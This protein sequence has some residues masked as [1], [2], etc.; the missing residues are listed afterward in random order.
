M[1]TITLIYINF[2]STINI[3][4]SIASIK[5]Y[6]TD[7]LDIIIGD[8]SGEYTSIYNE[9]VIKFE[10][11]IGFGRGVNQCFKNVKTKF[12][13][14]INPDT[15]FF[16]NILQ[17]SAQFHNIECGFVSAWQ[18]DQTG[19]F[20]LTFGNFPNVIHSLLNILP[21]FLIPNTLIRRFWPLVPYDIIQNAQQF[22]S[23]Y[24]AYLFTSFQ[25]FEKFNG[26]DEEFFMYY[27]E[28]DLC[29][30]MVNSGLVHRIL[31]THIYYYHEKGFSTK[32][33]TF[34]ANK[35]HNYSRK[36]YFLKHYNKTLYLLDSLFI[37]LGKFK[38]LFSSVK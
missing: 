25:T 31:P 4:N 27:E 36:Y 34:K 7:H 35:H 1:E 33:P 2:N 30:R 37:L 38:G 26:F 9:Y 29:K 19:Q 16:S 32:S 10:E 18:V 6:Y 8:N 20:S 13:A 3:H 21:A 5:K 23:C 11:N 12:I 14:I 15:L 22:K 28:T 24:G 17:E